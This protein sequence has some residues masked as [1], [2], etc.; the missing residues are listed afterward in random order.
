AL[1]KLAG[2]QVAFVDM[3]SASGDVLPILSA[4][5]RVVITAT[6]SSFERN[7]SQFAGYFVAALAGDGADVDKDG[8]VSMLEAFRYAAAETKRHYEDASKIQTEH[9]Q[10]DD[11]GAK[12]GT[13]DPDARTQ[14]MLARR[15][16]LDAGGAVAR[17]NA[18]AG[19]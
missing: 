16:Y 19:D 11:M 15:F 9:A 7:E 13:P 10:L 4:P 3:T 8:R 18:G 2:Q 17:A 12:L 5:N 14:G 6:K 1:D